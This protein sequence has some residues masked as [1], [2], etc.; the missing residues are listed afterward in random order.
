MSYHIVTIDSPKAHL[1]CVNGQ[2]VCTTDEGRRSLP[3]E[4]ISAIIV[5]CFSAKIELRLLTEAAKLGIGLILCETYT[6]AAIVLPAMRSTDTALT[7]AWQKASP[8]TL[9][10]IWS[11][12]IDAKCANQTALA[13]AWNPLHPS[14]PQMQEA[15]PRSFPVKEAVVSKLYWHAFRDW[16]GCSDFARLRGEGL[17]NHCLDYGY[18]VLLARVLQLC[19]ACGLDPTFGIGHET[20]ER[21]TPLAYDLMEPFRPLVDARVADWLRRSGIPDE[22]DKAFK[23]HLLAFLE[24][25]VPYRKASKPFQFVLESVVRSF[26][27][28]LLENNPSLYVPWTAGNS[29]WAGC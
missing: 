1:N 13:A 25:P 2:F 16:V 21:A 3:L 10:A 26:R 5:C 15:L 18:A 9:A 12:T 7:R 4:D 22:L 17:P 24:T 8:E 29:K 27:A 19:Y 23:Q 14:L 6:P 28:A 20:A 11:A